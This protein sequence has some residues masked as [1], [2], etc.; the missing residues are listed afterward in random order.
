MKLTLHLARLRCS[1]LLRVW[2]V[3]VTA[4]RERLARED[5]AEVGSR[6][7][8]LGEELDDMFPAVQ[9]KQSRPLVRKRERS[10]L[11]YRRSLLAALLLLLPTAL[12]VA[13]RHVSGIVLFGC[14]MC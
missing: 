10:A 11:A 12:A 4:L 7:I 3:V 14:L 5:A 2:F 9:K 6:G 13:V 1:S 8:L